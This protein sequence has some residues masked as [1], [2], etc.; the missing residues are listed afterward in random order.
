MKALQISLS[1]SNWEDELLQINID[2]KLFLLFVSPDFTA[3]QELLDSL[4]DSYP[5]A[6]IIGCSTAGEISNINVH[7]ESVSLTAMC[8]DK[9]SIRKTAVRVDNMA[10][11]C[12]AGRE[13]A[14]QLKKKDLRHILFLVMA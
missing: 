4:S 14:R 10:D 12:D 13:L 11:S 1:P 8:F 5:D 9:V 7:D 3:K 2:A 6:A